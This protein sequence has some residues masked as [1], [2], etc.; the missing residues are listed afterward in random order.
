MPASLQL[1]LVSKVCWDIVTSIHLSIIQ[2]YLH[3]NM[4]TLSSCDEAHMG[5]IASHS[6]KFILYIQVFAERI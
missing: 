1:V 4:T 5:F 3:T 2:V 6:H